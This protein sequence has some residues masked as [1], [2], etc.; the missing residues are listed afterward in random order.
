L[1][2]VLPEI[3]RRDADLIIV[4]NGPPRHAIDFRDTEHVASPL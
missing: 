1:G 2:D 3:R 4:G